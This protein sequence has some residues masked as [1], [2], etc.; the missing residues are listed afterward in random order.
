MSKDTKQ[1]KPKVILGQNLSTRVRSPY[2]WTGVVGILGS[3]VVSFGGLLGVD[4]SS[5]VDSVTAGSSNIIELVFLIL[6]LLGV[7][8]DPNSKGLKDSEIVRTDYKKP[9]NDKDPNEFVQ[10]QSDVDYTRETFEDSNAEEVTE[11]VDG[12]RDVDQEEIEE[13]EEPE[14]LE[15]TEDPSVD[16]P[17]S[18]PLGSNSAETLELDKEAP[19]SLG[20]Q[21]PKS[22]GGEVE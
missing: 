21:T 12:L 19:K 22:K 16:N 4:L 13:E 20:D 2:F 9:R 11:S 8:V 1:K 18:A 14:Y 15:V 17:D 3:A 7:S 10:W 6:G 5:Q